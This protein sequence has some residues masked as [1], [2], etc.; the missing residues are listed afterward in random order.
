MPSRF[1]ADSNIETP[2][3][4]SQLRCLIRKFTAFLAVITV[5]LSLP[6]QPSVTINMLG[7]AGKPSYEAFFRTLL[8]TVEADYNLFSLRYWPHVS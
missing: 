6:Q 5:K 3:C 2:A 4:V 7:N 1:A 8:S